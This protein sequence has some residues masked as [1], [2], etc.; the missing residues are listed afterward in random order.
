MLEF[1]EFRLDTTNQCLW[2]RTES[3]EDERIRLSPRPFALL[4][5]L[6]EHPGRLVTE[7]EI[8]GAVWPKVYVQPES[9][10]TQLYEIRRVLRDDPKTPRYIETLPRRGYQFIA[11]VHEVL[12]AP[13]TAQSRSTHAHLVGRERE[14][15]ELQNHLR[16]ASGGKRQVV[17]V[18]GE[19]GIGKTALVDEF[20]RQAV[21]DV[22]ALRM[23]RGQSVE[24]Y[25]E[26]EAYYPILEALEQLCVGSAAASIVEILA[27][28]APTWLVQFPALLTERHREILR[29]EILGATRERMLREIATAFD[30]IAAET[31]LL[32]VLEDLQWVDH[33]TIDVIAV[34][35]RRRAMAKLML[36]GTGRPFDMLP[37][38][39][40]L[41]AL[42]QDLLVHQLCQKIDLEPLTED[43]VA[44]YLGA[45]SPHGNSPE[46]LA[47]LVYRHSG[48]NPLLMVA[49]LDHLTQRGLIAKEKGRW[50]VIA[51]LE[52][53]DV[54]V[55]ETLRQMLEAQIERL[56][57]KEQL[58][59]EAASVQGTTF[60]ASVCA[61]A[62]NGDVEGYESLYD[63]MA[64]RRRMVRE[65]G[66]QAFP[67]G[68]FSARCEF[69]HALYR[70]VLYRRQPPLRRRKMH[71]RVGE[72]LEAAYS[73]QPSE[74][75]AELA[76]H[77][78]ES[79]DWPRTIRYLRLAADAAERR[80]AHQEAIPLL[81][82]ALELT[83]RLPEPQRSA[84][85]IETLES[86]AVAYAAGVDPRAIEAYQTLA[87]KA[88]KEGCLDTQVRALL[89]LGIQLSWSN[90]QRCV[91]AL[92]QALQLCT[93]Q[94]DQLRAKTRV[95]AFARRVAARAWD[96]TDAA[97]CERALAYLRESCDSLAL[98]PQLVDYGIIPIVSS[99]Y[100]DAVKCLTEG[101]AALSEAG[102]KN[103]ST[104]MR[105]GNAQLL[106]PYPLM[107]LGRWGEAL[108]QI[109]A[110]VSE[111]QR[112]EHYHHI[113]SMHIVRSHIHLH[114]MDFRGARDI[115]ESAVPLVRDPL[116]RPAPQAPQPYPTR[117]RM[118]LIQA[119]I[120]EAGL[121][122]YARAQE[123]FAAARVASD[124]EMA[125][126][127]WYWRMLLEAG[128]TEVSIANGDL[129]RARADAERFLEVTQ[130][131]AERTWQCL[132]WEANARIALAEGALT[133]A[134]E[135]VTKGVATME[136]FEVPLAGWRLHATAIV[137]HQQLGNN[138]LAKHHRDISRETVLRLA[139]SLLPQN[140]QLRETFLSSKP[141]ALILAS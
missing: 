130:T 68:R 128:L 29:Q 47:Q 139:D 13:V 48:G 79:S 120:A 53:I 141:V 133:R 117:L 126:Y 19:P 57:E 36:I 81:E 136:G 49:T 114:A 38:G 129:S 37:P 112:N 105:Y 80:Y 5:Y 100:R 40:P 21:L 125:V 109:D 77:F 24:A 23:A 111:M 63:S 25:G 84:T 8:L 10:K 71:R 35:A 127:D 101:R 42:K 56:S 69:V 22:P 55:P 107:Y 41:R 64:H 98:A 44:E 28:Q 137:V 11:P 6:V 96:S 102:G 72:Q 106:L 86:L 134:E 26:T 74:V 94:H 85:E 89:A 15:L 93:N 62:I 82:H 32:L 135:C 90:T 3:G 88:A 39:H 140:R 92:D 18:C 1:L 70:E 115:C 27:A 138:E 78:E 7:D 33:S 118:A 60:S 73:P 30:A 116:P 76:Y 113:Q 54:S 124:S 2:R 91:E 45:D 66:V 75:A 104:D 65:V 95:T 122:N 123:N 51:P 83:R 12:T 61:A 34:M 16:T 50:R 43:H 110:A 4:R 103:P 97:E 119:G 132:A 9:V 58:A 14:L 121:G 31:P 99:Q 108:R 46:G 59:L 67:D 20:Q 131:T 87:A 17:F 52:E